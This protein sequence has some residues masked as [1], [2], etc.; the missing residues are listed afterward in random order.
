MLIIVLLIKMNSPGPAFYVHRRIGRDGREFGCIKFRTMHAD[1]DARLSALLARDLSAAL[2]YADR[3]KLGNDPRII[4]GIG[5]VLRKTSL[6]EVPQFLNVLKGDMSVIG[7]R[8]VT[9]EELDR[10]YGASA[11]DVLSARPGISGLWQVSGRSGLSYAERVQ[12]DLEY[13]RDW[14]FMRDVAILLRTV[15]VVILRRGAC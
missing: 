1:S 15:V 13:V 12:L 3:A 7:P 10:H 5:T 11:P 8:P 4:A 6:D 2:E 14:G 9:Q